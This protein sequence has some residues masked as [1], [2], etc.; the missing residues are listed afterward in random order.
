M[1]PSAPLSSENSNAPRVGVL[2]GGALGLAAAYRLVQRG[3]RVTVLEKESAVGG[4][5][6]SFPV[7]G[8][9]LEK[10]YHHIFRSDRVITAL[11][12]ELGLGNKLIWEKPIT[13]S[14]INGKVYKMDPVHMLLN[15]PLSAVD[16]LRMIGAMGYL[17]LQPN[18]HRFE[19]QLAT[20]WL[21]KWMGPN[22][23]DTIW[24]PLL[25]QKF[26]KH[27]ENVAMPWMWARVYCRSLALGYLRGGFHQLYVTL[28][29]RIKSMGGE[30]LT[31]QSVEAIEA[32]PDDQVR[33]VVNG[34]VRYFDRVISTLPTRL[35]MKLARGL[36]DSYRQQYDWGNYH[37]AHCAILALDRPLGNPYWLSI[38]DPGY[39][40]LVAV[41]H[42]NYL[43]ASD[44][45]GRHLIYLGNYV[46]VDDKRFGMRDDAVLDW[47]LPHLRKL[48]PAFDPSW[49]KDSW[50]FKTPFAQ[51]IVTV[52]YH[53][54]IPPHETPIRNLF[55][56]NMFQVYPQ[57]RGQNYSIQ[58]AYRVADLAIKDP[59]ARAVTG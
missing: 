49:V 52:D 8:S 40:F 58:L 47:Y 3:A 9:Y 54:H 6:A 38:H 30:V 20:E 36:P 28:L 15:S 48:N 32:A 22:V 50:V 24:K 45:G 12:D 44:Y 59:V 19:G 39:P 55:L 7:G 27:T 51:P 16:R 11:I 18:Y 26:G 17:K 41:E 21:R 35:F 34:Q 2:G 1:T 53:N 37:G 25:E 23:Y 33:V 42:T 4:L 13:A 57:D 43:P 10:Y 5:A 31:E 29:D 56:A 14:L 46:P